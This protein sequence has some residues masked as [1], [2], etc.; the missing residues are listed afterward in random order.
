MKLQEAD[1]SPDNRPQQEPITPYTV[2][3]NFDAVMA[4]HPDPIV[5]KIITYRTLAEQVGSVG[6]AIGVNQSSRKFDSTVMPRAVPWLTT[7]HK[8]LGWEPDSPLSQYAST[9]IILVPAEKLLWNLNNSAGIVVFDQRPDQE[10][11][12]S[13]RLTAITNT[14]SA[15]RTAL[16]TL[17]QTHFPDKPELKALLDTLSKKRIGQSSLL[18]QVLT[19]VAQGNYEQAWN[20]VPKIQSIS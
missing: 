7:L 17:Q 4:Y 9:R 12:N 10:P 16:D 18:R 19:A 15:V 2:I 8:T 6:P 20:V 1:R 3:N 13:P 11:K 14:V 5:Q